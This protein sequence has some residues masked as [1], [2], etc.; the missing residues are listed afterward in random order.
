MYD[1][2]KYT[3]IYE[4]ESEIASYPYQVCDYWNRKGNAYVNLAI[5]DDSK[6]VGD[7]PELYD[8]G[9][10]YANVMVTVTKN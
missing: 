2:N 10:Y 4:N 1:K 3:K 8:N 9:M 5:T 7:N 6:T